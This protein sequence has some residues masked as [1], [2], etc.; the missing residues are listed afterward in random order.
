MSLPSTRTV[1]VLG[2]G[3]FGVTAALELKRRGWAV[4]LYD[5]G[6]VPHPHAAST[7]ISKIIRADYG[8]DGFY[9][10]LAEMAMD[11]W[12]EWSRSWSYQPFDATGFLILS[13]HPLED[14][15]FEAESMKSARTR[16]HAV[17]ELRGGEDP[18]PF[19]KW[20]D[21][22]YGFGYVHPRAGWSPSGRVMT[23]LSEQARA[24][25]VEI[26]EHRVARALESTPM[27]PR[28]ILEDLRTSARLTDH[29]DQVVVATGSWTPEVLPELSDRVRASG[30]VTVHFRVKDPS[31]WAPPHFLPWTADIARAGWYGF[32]ALP[33][34]RLKVANHGPGLPVMPGEPREA[35]EEPVERVRAFAATVFPE[36]ETAPVVERRLCVYTDTFDNDF[37]VAEHPDRTGVV[38]ATG[39]SGHGFKFAP[40]LG[41][42]I[43]DVVESRPNPWAHR[44]AWRELGPSRTEP[45][46]FTG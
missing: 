18:H 27:G 29:A 36:L 43:A 19:P 42:I 5:P 15:T 8:A 31:A 24:A 4:R 39:G 30:Q 1:I 32:P 22:P 12:E 17:R 45:A 6:P 3:V 20:K 35:P 9:A 25:G 11:G 38:V 7:D 23:T 41:G 26:L 34:G 10:D 33:D 40:V 28:V 44:F 14:G 2:A 46:R 21:S 37:L 16:G 13:S